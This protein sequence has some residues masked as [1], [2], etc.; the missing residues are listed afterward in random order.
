MADPHPVRIS[1]AL[2]AND[3]SS[4]AEPASCSRLIG[5]LL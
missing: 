1:V 3:R 4:L 5:P 2:K